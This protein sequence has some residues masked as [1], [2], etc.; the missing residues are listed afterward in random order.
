MRN[1]YEIERDDLSRREVLELIEEHLKNMHEISP[2]ENVFSFDAAKLKAA[3]ITFWTAWQGS[4]LLGCAALK[5]LSA[6]AGEVKS[7]RTVGWQR[8]AGVGRALLRHV[9]EVAKSRGY[10]RLYL[11]T[12]R[13]PAFV[14]AHTLYRS[15]GFAFCGPFGTYRE[16]DFSVFMCL[17]L[18][19]GVA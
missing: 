9:V 16:S 12:G 2:P 14:P 3:D 7:M 4:T 15:A 19:Q 1:D 8:R 6:E 5:E 13:H 18:D 17:S 10:Q 11:E